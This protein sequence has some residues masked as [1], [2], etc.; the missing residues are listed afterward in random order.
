M[1]TS[2]TSTL[3]RAGSIAAR[4][5]EEYEAGSDRPLGSF[6]TIMGVYLA[7]VGALGAVLRR[8]GQVLPE[9][10]SATDLALLTVATHKLS[11]LLAKDPVTSPLRAPF[12]RFAGT[13]GPAE[14][15]EKV[16]GTG[17]RRGVGA[18]VTCPFCL[19]VWVAT[20]FGFSLVLAPRATRFAASILTAV[21]GAD[22]LHF[23]YAALEQKGQ[24]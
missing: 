6:L 22:V 21:A 11:R 14:L 19:A 15:S 23:A 10:V 18:L 5:K 1:N 7:G 17:L 8:R 20:A 12:T 2:K 24:P 4:E 3:E 16:R 9:R 13:S